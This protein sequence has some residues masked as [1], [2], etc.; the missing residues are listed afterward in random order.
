MSLS[1][2]VAICT[3]NNALLLDR[4]LATI[5]EQ[6]VDSSITWSVLVVDNNS[7]DE[8]AAIAQ[9]YIDAGTI[10]QLR[11]VKE[12]Q[13]GLSY[14]RICAVR[15]TNSE[16]IAFVDDDCLLSPDWVQQAV[17]FFQEHP[18]AGAVGS[19]VKL[20][21]EVPPPE[22]ILP[23]QGYLSAYDRGDL[24]LQM[25]SV[26]NTY[27]VGAGLVVRR[28]ALLASG[29]LE[30]TALVGRNG[31]CLTA[32]DDSEIV[33]RIRNAGYELWYNPAMQLQHYIPQKRISPQYLQRLIRGIGQSQPFLYVLGNRLQPNLAVRLSTCG[34]SMRYF[35]KVLTSI[36]YR[37]LFQAHPLTAE[38]LLY[39][40]HS[41]GRLQG[42]LQ[43]F[44]R[45]Y[46]V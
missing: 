44:L 14:A 6:Q 34:K 13:Q 40:N 32:G 46:Q 28:S 21:W 8:T 5:A 43:L 36:I 1:I 30:K 20:L 39:L 33:L 16:L 29:W 27:L 9:R 3:Y 42:A 25:P 10:P 11:L 41:L 12:P 24:P 38:R 45:G 15:S 19:R 23:F 22:E 31:K 26:G 18:Q 4:T 7:T 17:T 37:N 2:E 35:S